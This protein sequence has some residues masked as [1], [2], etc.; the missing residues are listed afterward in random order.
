MKLG[1]VIQQVL[2]EPLQKRGFEYHKEPDE[3]LYIRNCEYYKEYIAIDKSNWNKNAIR[4]SYYNG[5]DSISDFWLIGDRLKEWHFYEDE[6]T[7]RDTLNLILD[8][9]INQA[10]PWFEMN[11]PEDRRGSKLSEL[12]SEE[13]I[14]QSKEFIEKN[15]LNVAVPESLVKL[16]KLLLEDS[17]QESLLK[18]AYFFGE[19]L[20]HHLNGEWGK[21]ENG[22]PIIKCIG[23]KEDFYKE[24]FDIVESYLEYPKFNSVYNHFKALQDTVSR[25]K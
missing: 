4:T 7:L 19:V 18:S 2:S 9:T 11:R 5:S 10:L 25:L 17:S 13:M 20:I 15:E 1:K 8:I 16:E 21:D 22:L 23:G 6:K 24:P 14:K 12:L 3:W